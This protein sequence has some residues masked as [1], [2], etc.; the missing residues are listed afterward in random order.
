MV[1][2][3]TRRKGWICICFKGKIDRM[4]QLIILKQD[5]EEDGSCKEE[6]VM[7]LREEIMGL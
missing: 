7:V 6:I 2:V 1:P 5:E 4:W 3:G